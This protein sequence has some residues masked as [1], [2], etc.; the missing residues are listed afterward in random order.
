[1]HA[2]LWNI[3]A[4]LRLALKPTAQGRCRLFDKPGYLAQL[5]AFNVIVEQQQLFVIV[6]CG[7][8]LIERRDGRLAVMLARDPINHSALAATGLS[9]PAGTIMHL[10]AALR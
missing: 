9:A 6:E 5:Q 7:E 10:A 1:M 2:T 8:R 3:D 4:P